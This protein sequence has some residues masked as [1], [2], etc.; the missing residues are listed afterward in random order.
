MVDFASAS[1]RLMLRARSQAR[2]FFSAHKKNFYDRLSSKKFTHVT[3][4]QRQHSYT[5]RPHTKKRRFLVWNRTVKV[6]KTCTLHFLTRDTFLKKR[7]HATQSDNDGF[8]L[9][10]STDPFFKGSPV[11]TGIL[12]NVTEVIY[13]KKIFFLSRFLKMIIFINSCSMIIHWSLAL[14][15]PYGIKIDELWYLQSKHCIP[16]NEICLAALT[17]DSKNNTAQQSPR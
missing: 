17:R 1:S 13:K 11:A 2:F 10:S 15:D 14:F 7:Y 8:L 12:K 6:R 16:K 9:P 5:H 3:F 4:F